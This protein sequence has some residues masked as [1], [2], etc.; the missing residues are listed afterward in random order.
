MPYWNI[1]KTFVPLSVTGTGRQTK[2][3]NSFCRKEKG[4]RAPQLELL[5]TLGEGRKLGGP[6]I[7]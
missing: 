2:L 7:L 3:G 1:Q 4:R 6:E 5:A